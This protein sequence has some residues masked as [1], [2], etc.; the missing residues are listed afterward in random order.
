MGKMRMPSVI[1][2]K[3]ASEEKTEDADK[4]KKVSRVD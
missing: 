2:D 4:G 3:T 1:L